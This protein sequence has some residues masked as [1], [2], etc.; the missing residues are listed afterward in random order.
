MSLSRQ[1]ADCETTIRRGEG[2]R[3]ELGIV[4][5]F[6]C[7]ALVL[8]IASTIFAPESPANPSTSDISLIGP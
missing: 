3:P 5:V 7:A 4:L 8:V 2:R 6:V 1:T